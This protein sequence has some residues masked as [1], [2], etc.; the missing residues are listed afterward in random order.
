MAIFKRKSVR[1]SGKRKTTH[2]QVVIEQQTVAGTRRRVTVGT[3]PTRK[4]AAAEERKALEARNRGIDLSPRTVTISELL[5]RFVA[6]RRSKGRALRTLQRYEELATFS[7]GKHLGSLPLAKLSP[8]HLSAW[9]SVLSEK[10]SVSGKPLS[11][12]SVRHAFALLRAALRWAVRHDLAGRNAADA[13]DA[14]SVPRSE[15][16]ALGED[17]A[18]QFLAFADGTRWGPFFRLALG[19]GAR[20]GELLALRWDDVSIPSIGQARLTIRRAFVELKGKDQHLVEKSTKTDRVRVIPLGVLAIDALRRQR[21]TQGE[22]RLAAGGLVADGGRYHDSAHVFQELEGGPVWPDAATKAFIR[23]RRN[24]KVQATLH[25][26]RHTAASWM[27]AGG[28]DVAAVARILGHT[29]PS[30]TLG[31][32]AHALPAAETRAMMAIDERLASGKKRA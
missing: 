27:L 9:L 19:T 7:I 3:F 25:D 2:Y 12:K 20:R 6:D 17:E 15:A 18:A 16:R 8:A 11:P 32:Y 13:V 22:D 21:V 24:A 4:E 30:T 31:I 29:T 1:K 5:E 28:V 26:L 10:G 23:L 14:P